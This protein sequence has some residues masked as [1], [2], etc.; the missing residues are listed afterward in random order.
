FLMVGA[1]AVATG[2]AYLGAPFIS[3]LVFPRAQHVDLVR[4]GAAS[5]FCQ[6]LL[7][8]PFAFLQAR[9]RSW[10]FV[11]FNAVKLVL[12]LSLNIGLVVGLG[13]GAKG[14]LLSSLITNAII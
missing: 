3:H 9:E 4:I 14:V 10:L 11:S 7:L 13:L 5:L 12:Q 6:S 1:F 8:V 2:L